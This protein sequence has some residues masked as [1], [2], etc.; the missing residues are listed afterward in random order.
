MNK[1]EPL[2]LE[3]EK[4]TVSTGVIFITLLVIIAFRIRTDSFNYL[5][6]SCL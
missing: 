3:Y 6:G 5:L 4:T 1:K 2:T